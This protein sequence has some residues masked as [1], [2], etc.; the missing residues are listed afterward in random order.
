VEGN[1]VIPAQAENDT[2]G[3][4]FAFLL[5]PSALS[6]AA[7]MAAMRPRL[8]HHQSGSA[9]GENLILLVVFVLY[10]LMLVLAFSQSLAAGFGLVGLTIGVGAMIVVWG[11]RRD[12]RMERARVDAR[13][14]DMEQ[15][16]LARG[17]VIEALFIGQGESGMAVFGVA[18]ATRTIF[19]ARETYQ[20][21]RVHAVEFEQVA[22]AFAR[23]DGEN[24]YRLELR[25]RPGDD[26]SPRAALFLGVESREEAGRWVQVLEPH[27]GGRAKFISAADELRPKDEG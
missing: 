25:I 13:L 19:F 27:L 4:P 12:R 5:P 2:P 16:A 1:A 14:S 11:Q 3:F 22:A 26:R 21:E 9:F 18:G 6:Q 23:P 24:R 20:K 17:A 7:M 8:R 10:G 15:A